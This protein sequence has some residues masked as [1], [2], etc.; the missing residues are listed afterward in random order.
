MKRTVII[1]KND[2]Q[3]NGG[4]YIGTFETKKN[5]K[6]LSVKFLINLKKYGW[7]FS[8]NFINHNNNIVIELVRDKKPTHELDTSQFPK[9]IAE[10]NDF[11]NKKDGVQFELLKRTNT[12]IFL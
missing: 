2:Y 10:I 4:F 11:I 1:Q 8:S 7:K 3:N 6:K 12:N 5:Y 9:L